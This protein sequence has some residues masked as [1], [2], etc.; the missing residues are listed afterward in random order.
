[1]CVDCVLV[2]CVS[3]GIMSD[4]RHAVV[5]CDYIQTYY[6]WSIVCIVFQFF[7]VQEWCEVYSFVF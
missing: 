3:V 5:S 7:T 4:T 2:F 6:R 1:M